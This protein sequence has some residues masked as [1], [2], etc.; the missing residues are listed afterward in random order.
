MT[1]GY[2]DIVEGEDIAFIDWVLPD[3]IWG[4]YA[5]PKTATVN[6]TFYS[7]MYPGDTPRVYGPY[8][9]TQAKKYINT[10]IR[11]RQWAMKIDGSDV[12]SFARLGKIR[13]RV[14]MDGRL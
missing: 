6:L 10:R 14:A 5:G 12:G 3:M 8:A 7:Q 13:Y 1:T 9:V 2:S 11:G 4:T